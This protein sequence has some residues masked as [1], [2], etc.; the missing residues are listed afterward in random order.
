MKAKWRFSIF[1]IILSVLG[2]GMQ[3]FSVPNQEIVVQFNND[4]ISLIETQ[5]TIS[6]VKKQLQEIGVENIKVHQGVN[7]SLKI[8]YHSDV[9]VASIKKIL[10]ERNKLDLG[11]TSILQKEKSSKSSS[12]KNSNSYKLDVSKIQKNNSSEGD[13][14]G[15]ALEIKPKIDR[16]YYPEFYFYTAETILPEQNIIEK[17]AYLVYSRIS[18]ILDKSS[19]NI[20]EV[21]AGPVS[22]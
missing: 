22:V 13:F 6:I 4:T 20:P 14:N 16:V 11:L 7:G 21:R 3:Q 12:N 15:L 2:I 10:S 8:T 18:I 5:N 17:T 1:I 9:D 19:H